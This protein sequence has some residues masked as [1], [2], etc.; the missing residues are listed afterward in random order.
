MAVTS[1][2]TVIALLLTIIVT[3]LV[4]R[5]IV[6]PVQKERP[7]PPLVSWISMMSALPTLL[8][9]GQQ[10]VIQDLHTKL[11]SVFTLSFFGVKKVTFLVGPEVTA[12]FY[13]APES[14]ISIDNL[15]EFTVPI[16]GKGVL[17]DVD[18]ATRSKQIRFCTDAIKPMKLKNHVDSLVQEV[19]DYFSKWGQEGIVDL[20]H[21]IGNMLMLI[22]GRCLLG[23]D[24]RGTMLG[25][26]S[27][28]LHD[29][30][31]NGLHLFS[32]FFPYLPIPSHKQRDKARTKLGE[33]FGNIVRSRK[34]SSHIGVDV[35][36]N[37]IDSQYKDEYSMS[38][39]EITGLLIALLFGGH[40]SSS[41][42]ATWTGACL[43][44][45]EK[46][47]VAAIE[48]QKE[49]MGQYGERIDY[50]ILLEMRTLHCC[51]K[52]ALRMHA[53][54]SLLIRHA[55]KEFSVQTREGTT[56]EIPE[57]HTLASSTVVS[58][59]LSYIYKDP[60]IYD[61]YRFSEGREEDKVGVKFCYTSF[62]GGRHA[63]LGEHFAYMQIKVIWSYLLRNFE[64]KLISPFPEDEWEKFI[65]GPRG[66]VMVS[67]K[68]QHLVIT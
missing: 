51:I 18:L 22:A 66:K 23:V 1:F 17:Y 27:T 11:G 26:V 29:I 56:Y 39:D 38:D 35:L 15:Y 34:N 65:P 42:T 63:C 20:K 33:M 10:V 50:N 54:S 62:S 16:F 6:G 7:A 61:P 48:E 28:L 4:V 67:Y 64:L 19:Q 57:G 25:E 21:E 3:K 31:H 46:Y 47:L 52:E 44:S 49:V 32:F 12:H 55:K 43:L 60:H 8:T 41:N 59:N 53:T 5:K 40:H 45:H 2:L 68:R 36:Q 13:Q 30:D 9:K 14:E 58:N 37:F 24:I